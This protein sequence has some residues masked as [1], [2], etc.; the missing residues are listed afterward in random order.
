MAVEHHRPF[1]PIGGGGPHVQEEA[2]F[3]RRRLIAALAARLQ[4]RRAQL[5]GIT[6]PCPGL[7]RRCGFEAARSGN[8]T[9][10]GDA[11]EGYEPGRLHAANTPTR[12]VRF[13]KFTVPGV[14]EGV[15]MWKN[16]GTGQSSRSA[17]DEFAP[18]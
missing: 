11:L 5:Q 18:R 3:V 7:K 12:R 1:T 9:C 15:G 17:C 14:Y 13:N 4:R 16:S 8:R 6:E 2:V 10:V